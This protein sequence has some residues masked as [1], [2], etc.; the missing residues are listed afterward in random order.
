MGWDFIIRWVVIGIGIVTL[1][2]LLKLLFFPNVLDILV[3]I[4][5]VAALLCLVQFDKD[6][7][8]HHGKC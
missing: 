3:I 1:L 2:I 7:H 4:I 6:N 8:N 5:L